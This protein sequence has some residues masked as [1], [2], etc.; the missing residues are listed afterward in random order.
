MIREPARRGRLY[1]H[2]SL[3]PGHPELKT[4]LVVDLPK[5]HLYCDP[6][7]VPPEKRADLA[8]ELERLLPHPSKQM[9]AKG[10]ILEQLGKKSRS[11]KLSLWLSREERM[12]IEL[13]WEEYAPRARLR[14][15][16]LYFISDYRRC[17]P[18]G[19]LLGQVM[20]TIRDEKDEENGQAIPTGGLELMFDS[21]LQGTEGK[22]IRHRSPRRALGLGRVLS[23]PVPGADLYLT[24]DHHLQAIAEEAVEKGVRTANA[25]GGWA[26]LMDPYSG[27]IW[28][29]AQY[30]FF[31]PSHYASYFQDDKGMQQTK[32]KAAIDAYEPGSIF[33]PLIV[34]LFL[35]ANQ[36]LR[37]RGEAPLFDPD[38]KIATSD[39]RVPGRHQKPIRDLRFHRFMNMDMALQKSSNVY[40]ARVM[41]RLIERMGEE[42]LRS[43]LQKV[44]GIGQKTGV[45]LPGEASGF[46]P[47]LGKKY[48]SGALEWSVPT[49][50][51]MAMGH[52]LLATGL[53]L[54]R[55]YAI[56]AN[57]GREVTPHLVRKVVRSLPDG[58]E[59]ILLDRSAKAAPTMGEQLLD[60]EIAARMV[61]TLKYATKSGGSATRADIPGYTEAGKSG[62][63]EKV[64]AGS[65]SKR[66]HISF[67][68]G[69]APANH[70]RFVLLVAID[71]PEYKVGVGRN[72]LG[73][74]CA[75]PVFR[76]IG[77]RTLEYLGVPPDDPFSGTKQADW[78]D[79]A[80]RLARLY[81]E[82][83]Q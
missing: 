21:I 17:Y 39:G 18:F 26:I 5:F 80:E 15:G 48:A 13:W 38:G 54:V 3:R 66:D 77:L 37:Q 1:A 6:F 19:H 81:R 4:P 61:R 52:N 57:G 76:E 47:T 50:Y 40:L 22:R 74:V 73:G 49:P 28:A 53:Q 65:Y 24:I 36:E 78:Y 71:D 58:K 56:L 45:E 20:H 29:L 75:A 79:E 31:E 42:W 23:T 69:V 63:A 46:L 68:A 30:P 41:Q 10:W 33:K 14:R 62:T 44:F 82:W 34:A 43:R 2:P 32:V 25:S 70:P 51:S 16:V 55:G 60:P 83:N 59:E 64:I 67:F 72:Q 11:R 7:L 12:K 8:A 35:Q 27:E 9:S